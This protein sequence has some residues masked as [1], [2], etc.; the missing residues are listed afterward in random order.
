MRTNQVQISV[1]I[2]T[3][4][5]AE[6]LG[7]ALD[8]VR[9]QTFPPEGYEIIVVD[10]G[11]TDDTQELV[12]KIAENNTR[13]PAL[14]YVQEDRRGIFLAYHAG[15]N[16]ARGQFLA[17][18]DDDAT[19][20]TGWLAALLDAYSDS[21]VGCVGGKILPIWEA[22]PPIWVRTYG[23]GYFGGLDLGD[24]TLELKFPGVYNSNLFIPK[25]VLLQVGGFNPDSLGDFWL[26][27]G[28]IGLQWKLLLAGWKI[29]Y[30]PKAVVWHH[31]PANRMT[32]NYLK[33]RSAIQGA[34]NSYTAYRRNRPG[35][36]PLLVS[37]LNQVG[38]G[39]MFQAMIIGYRLLG[40]EKR[41]HY[42]IRASYHWRR[43]WYD[44]GLIYDRQFRELVQKD[45][46]FESA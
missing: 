41:Y 18:L 32:L 4:N 33:Q 14:R 21:Q 15:I 1:I 7:R 36:W 29:I 34:C 6:I 8:S 28:E 38:R 13:G 2:P 35:R 39:L 31:I 9:A 16:A 46:W 45:D 23:Y 25:C 26:G 5:R 11:C 12:S 43:V 42:E 10:N 24:D 30:T 37:A 3:F 40:N 20:D 22:E 19:A 17:F 44:L 27:D